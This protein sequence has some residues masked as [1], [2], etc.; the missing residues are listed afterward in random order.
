MRG[1]VSE[2]H[3][4][5][6]GDIPL[7]S[8]LLRAQVGCAIT[9]RDRHAAP[10]MSANRPEPDYVSLIDAAR[11]YDVAIESPLERARNLSGRLRRDVLMKREDLQ[12]VFSFKL[13]GAYNK[14]VALGSEARR[15]GVICS[16]AGNHAQGVALAAARLGTEATIVMPVTTPTIKV[17]AVAAQGGTVIL[18]GD[19]YDAAYAHACDIAAERNLTFIHPFDDPAVIAGQGTI[20]AE[21]RRQCATPPAAVFVPI[22]GGGLMAGIAVYL[23]AHWPTVRMVGVEPEDS[24]GMLASFAAGRPVTLDHVGIFADGVAVRRV[25]DETFRLCRAHV[26]EIVTVDTDRICAAI[27]D[28]FEDTRTIVEPAG[29]LAVAGLKKYLATADPG[30]GA[31]VTINCG[32]NVNFDRLRHIAERAAIGERKEMLLAV[33]IP[34]R[35]G[36]FRRFCE[37]LGRRSITEFNYRYSGGDPA[38]IFVGVQLQKGRR[39]RDELLARLRGH[40]YPVEDL[41]DNELAK[42]HVRHLVGGRSAG[43]ANERLYRFEFPE[44]PGALADF[45][46]AIGTDWNITLFHYRNHGS[47]YGR[48]LAGIDVSDDETGELEAHLEALGYPHFDETANPAYALFLA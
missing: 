16:S 32:A 37:H 1:R 19:N 45:L 33:E 15:R 3:A 7:R 42:L 25:G 30:D 6:R 36:S 44:R 12:S 48:V 14:L 17:D 26:D 34:E 18:H 23:K 39:E 8:K 28:I 4:A 31:L 13:R 24:A 46:D 35:P 47:D 10:T 11:V 41:S 22:G 38:H 5:P 29:A 9:A 21:L 40:D 27:Q 43:I 20:G 2:S